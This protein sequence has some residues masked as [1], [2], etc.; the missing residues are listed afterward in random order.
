MDVVVDSYLGGHLLG[1][2]E[3]LQKPLFQ[4]QSYPDGLCAAD[5]GAGHARLCDV[6]QLEMSSTTGDVVDKFS[7]HSSVEV[8]LSRAHPGEALQSLPGEDAS[9]DEVAVAD[10]EFSVDGQANLP[11]Q[12]RR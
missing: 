12:V 9:H 11:L 8:L 4:P 3:C 1:D 2:G 5:S 6:R 10:M 7:G